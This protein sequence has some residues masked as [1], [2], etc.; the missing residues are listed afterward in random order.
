[1]TNPNIFS[2]VLPEYPKHTN[3]VIKAIKPNITQIITKITTTPNDCIN[4][5]FDLFVSSFFLVSG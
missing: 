3:D 1:M 4:P 2:V 5:L